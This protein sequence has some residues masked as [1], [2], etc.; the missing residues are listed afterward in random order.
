VATRFG[1][2]DQLVEGLRARG[3]SEVRLAGK[4]ATS[5][6][7]G[8]KQITFRGRL[9]VSAELDEAESI[10]YEEQVRRVV[11]EVEAPELPINRKRATDLQA[12]QAALMRQLQAYRSEYQSVM[13][14]ARADLTQA[15]SRAGIS[16]LEA[17]N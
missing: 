11:T 9:T 17:E 2:L 5:T 7:P 6:S 14:S 4:V 10:E 8:G 13:E 1:T 16:V 15:L 12:A 3:V